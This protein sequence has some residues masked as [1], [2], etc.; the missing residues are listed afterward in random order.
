M[1]PGSNKIPTS[2]PKLPKEGS[3]YTSTV[4]HVSQVCVA[5]AWKIIQEIDFKLP[6]IDNKTMTQ[7]IKLWKL[8]HR[9]AAKSQM[10]IC[11]YITIILNVMVLLLLMPFCLVFLSFHGRRGSGP[12][13][14]T[15]RFPWLQA[16]GPLRL[17]THARIFCEIQCICIVYTSSPCNECANRY[18]F[19]LLCACVRSREG[20]RK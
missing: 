16:F 5:R 9:Q 2:I 15:T 4:T 11:K 14:K 3:V 17:V 1:S 12:P 19:V 7:H 8:S 13:W 10:S 20:T 18:V 6:E